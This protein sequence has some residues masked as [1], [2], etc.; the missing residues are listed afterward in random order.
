MWLFLSVWTFNFICTL[1][2][3]LMVW[4]Y[5]IAA[6]VSWVLVVPSLAFDIWRMATPDDYA[7]DGPH[8]PIWHNPNTVLWIHL[9][10]CSVALL[11]APLFSFSCFAEFN[12]SI[13]PYFGFANRKLVEAGGICEAKY[14]NYIV[15]Y[16]VALPF[17]QI[18]LM[19]YLL[20]ICKRCRKRLSDFRNF[21]AQKN[22]VERKDSNLFLMII[23]S[24]G[25]FIL[26]N[27]ISFDNYESR[28]LYVPVSY[29]FSLASM[30]IFYFVFFLFISSSCAIG[31]YFQI[32]QGRSLT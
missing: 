18:G 20:L 6:P 4:V 28:L 27:Y 16:F 25:F 1:T 19:F 13:E 5:E 14:G 11:L 24:F 10:F 23:V 17:F 12:R 15:L 21:N 3:L 30:Q 31:S 32:K 7:E 9:V 2:A 8:H 22:G 29:L 26:I